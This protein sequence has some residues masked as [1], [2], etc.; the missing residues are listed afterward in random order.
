MWKTVGI[1]SY[2]SCKMVTSIV[3]LHMAV[4]LVFPAPFMWDYF[5]ALHSALLIVS[6]S[7]PILPCFGHWNF[8]IEF[9][10]GEWDDHRFN[11]SED[12]FGYLGSFVI[13]QC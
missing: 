10:V 3:I 12:C 8:V 6:D 13:P 4:C 1:V 7:M 5:W 11:L 2:F 9:E